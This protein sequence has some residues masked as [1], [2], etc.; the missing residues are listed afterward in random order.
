[1]CEEEVSMKPG[2]W[3]RQIKGPITSNQIIFDGLFGIF[4]P[5]LCF[6]LDPIAFKGGFGRPML[7]DHQIFA[8]LFSGIEMV[9]LALWLLTRIKSS[10]LSSFLSG[11]FMAGGFFCAVLGAI[12]LPYSLLGLMVVIGAL[13]FTPFI[14]GF[15]FFRNGYRAMVRSKNDILYPSSVSSLLLG[16]LFTLVGPFVLATGINQYVTTSVDTMI[17]G[18]EQQALIAARHVRPL[19]FVAGSKLQKIVAEY[20]TT[21]DNARRERLGRLYKEATGEE[22]QLGLRM[23][24]D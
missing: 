12:L 5:L 9:L 13:G 14:T 17:F 8:Y 3:F 20:Q 15:V 24:D 6:L 22:I 11:V 23:L 4:G 7:E 1:M 21:S 10:L 2:F 19:S 18:T 16:G